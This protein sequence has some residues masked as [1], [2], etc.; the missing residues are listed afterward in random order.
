VAREINQSN[1]NLSGIIKF[2]IGLSCKVFIKICHVIW[3]VLLVEVD[4]CDRIIAKEPAFGVLDLWF[5]FI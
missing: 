1:Q 3:A 4:G 2:N 5:S